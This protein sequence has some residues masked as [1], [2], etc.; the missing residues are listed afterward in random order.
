MND[1]TWSRWG[2]VWTW[3]ATIGCLLFMAF[4]LWTGLIGTC[5]YFANPTAGPGA[6]WIHYGDACAFRRLPQFQ[7]RFP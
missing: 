1:A 2:A 3:A 4:L 5:F 6:F 7:E